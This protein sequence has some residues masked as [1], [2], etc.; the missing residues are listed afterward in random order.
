MAFADRVERALEYGKSS[1]DS[2]DTLVIIHPEDYKPLDPTGFSLNKELRVHS[3]R[4]ISTGSNKFEK[5]FSVDFQRAARELYYPDGLPKGID[6][7]LDLRLVAPMNLE[8]AELSR[9]VSEQ[10]ISELRCSRGIR[11][12]FSS[13][14]L[15]D[16]PSNIVGGRDAIAATGSEEP[17]IPPKKE[18][19]S[20]KLVEPSTEN[21]HAKRQYAEMH[22]VQITDDDFTFHAD[23]LQALKISAQEHIPFTQDIDTDEY[24]MDTLTLDEVSEYCPVRYRIGVEHL[25]QIIEGREPTWLNSAPKIWTLYVVAKYFEC[26]SYVVRFPN[27]SNLQSSLIKNLL[28]KE[29]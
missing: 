2:G 6:F 8:D 12:W 3:K 19:R 29:D 20:G 27:P 1:L 23:M 10:L 28:I 5:I 26:T 18:V 7:I 13:Q 14:D 24:V 22:D 25:L 16:V 17:A 9:H 15:N 4:L 21:Q 11:S